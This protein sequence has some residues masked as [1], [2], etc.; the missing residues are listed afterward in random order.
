MFWIGLASIGLFREFGKFEIKVSD[1]SNIYN[2]LVFVTFILTGALMAFGGWLAIGYELAGAAIPKVFASLHQ[3]GIL[4]VWVGFIGTLLSLDSGVGEKFGR[5]VSYIYF[6]GALLYIIGMLMFSF[7]VSLWIIPV[8]GGFISGVGALITLLNILGFK[9]ERESGFVGFIRIVFVLIFLWLTIYIMYGSW[10]FGYL[11]TFGGDNASA[12]LSNYSAS[13]HLSVLK[14]L[15]QRNA[16][17]SLLGAII[18]YAAYKFG[19]EGEK[20]NIVAG[21]IVLAL[22]SATIGVGLF[23]GA[24]V[25]KTVGLPIAAIVLRL[26]EYALVI[27]SIYLIFTIPR[28]K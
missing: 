6:G 5:L 11:V 18:L 17:W 1:L 16:E 3:H 10:Y 28:V 26:G 23:Y 2:Y 14:T 15:H 9:R 8:L 19:F 13:P 12:I 27:L 24:L 22:L 21:F 20:I 7:F 4:L 25:L